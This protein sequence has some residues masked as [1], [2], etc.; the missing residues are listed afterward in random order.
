MDLGIKGEIALLLG[1]TQGLALSCAQHLAEA[2]VRV[3]LNGRGRAKGEAAIR[4]FGADAYFVRGDVSDPDDR[5]RIFEA[6]RAI[7]RPITILVTNAG[8]P[9][10]GQFGEHDRATWLKAIETNMLAAVDFAERCLPDMIARGFGRIVN[11]TSF[12]VREPY[13]NLLL[14]NSV[15]AGLHGAMA[16]LA[17]EVAAKGVT[18]NN[19]LPGLMDTPALQRVY[20]AQSLRENISEDDA[21][22]RMAAAVPAR[23]LGTAEDFGPAC[24]FLCSR[25]ASYITGQ[26][27]TIDGGLVRSLL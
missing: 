13:P 19:L 12:A 4:P 3:I 20:R 11:I 16:T 22:R 23:R 26:N 21:K 10:P 25:H 17:R 1:G 27:L 9:P 18:V 5:A 6:A 2:G 14:A 7:A 15:R 24:A 8:G